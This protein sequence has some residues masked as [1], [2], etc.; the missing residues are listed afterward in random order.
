MEQLTATIRQ[1]E[2]YYFGETNGHSSPDLVK[3]TETWLARAN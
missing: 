1:V 2:E 3:L